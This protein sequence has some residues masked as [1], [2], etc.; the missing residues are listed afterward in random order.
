MPQYLAMLF[1]V[2]P[3]AAAAHGGGVDAS[4]CHTKR[5]TGDYH[6]HRGGAGK[7][8]AQTEAA[9][10]RALASPSNGGGPICYTGPRGG[11]Y[12]ITPSGS[13]NYSGC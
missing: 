7:I 3:L 9:T 10:Q 2:V 6:C 4:G 1:L 13:K 5:S 12:T 11:T 8:P